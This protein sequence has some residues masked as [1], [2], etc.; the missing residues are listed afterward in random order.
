MSKIMNL[1]KKNLIKILRVILFLIVIAFIC[2]QYIQVDKIIPNANAIS[3]YVLNTNS[4]KIHIPSCASANKMSKKN[5]KLV[6]AH[7]LDLVE[8]GYTICYN[9]YAGLKRRS[10]VESILDSTIFR[11]ISELKE[12][13]LPTVDEYLNAVETMCKW[14][15]EHIP[16]YLT[17]LEAETIE[18]YNQMLPYIVDNKYKGNNITTY[19]LFNKYKSKVEQVGSYNV[20]SNANMGKGINMHD[21]DF[22]ILK[23]NENAVKYYY[24]NYKNIKFRKS[25]AYYPC[26]LIKDSED[27]YNMAGD[28]CVRLIFSALNYMDKGFTS[29]LKKYSKL[30]WSKITSTKIAKNREH[31]LYAFQTLGFKTYD[32]NEFTYDINLDGMIDVT[33]NELNNDFEL[34]KGDIIA[35]PGHV[36]FYLG[37]G[38]VINVENFGWGKVNRCYPQISNIY[39]ENNRIKFV[40]L[41]NTKSEYYTR[42]YRYVGKEK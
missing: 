26:E 22:K 32:L 25:F 5:K 24:D 18:N 30:N 6:N 38:K 20:I 35:R 29:K 11:N 8:D 13:E 14:Y 4:L 19:N 15:T 12:E 39:I 3:E 27:D 7:I 16:T 34:H 9:C 10:I 1:I 28:D 40:N 41:I 31:L 2:R 17:E 42:V 33:I 37:D 23:A 36:H 21:K